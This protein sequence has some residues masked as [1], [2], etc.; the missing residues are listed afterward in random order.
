MKKFL[1]FL[2]ATVV[3]MAVGFVPAVSAAT[4]TITNT[5]PSSNNTCTVS[6]TTRVTVTCVNGVTVT[7]LNNQNTLSGTATVSGNTVSGDALSGTAANLNAAATT[8][9]QNCA[10]AAATTPTPVA[11]TTTPPA[12][13]GGQGA[14]QGA[15]T[16]K[17]AA[18]PNT[19]PSTLVTGIAVS[20]ATVGALA[21]LVHVV[22]RSYRRRAFKV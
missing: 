7:N 21:G 16:T 6:A 11:A 22:L 17:V 1:Q 4:C 14:V 13:T 19:G 2:S 20:A 10:T 5:G 15:S 9:A 8:L 3:T 18:L 12:A